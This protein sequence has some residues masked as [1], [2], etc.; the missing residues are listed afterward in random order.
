MHLSVSKLNSN[1][2][3]Q[4]FTNNGGRLAMIAVKLLALIKLNT[5]NGTNAMQREKG[6]KITMKMK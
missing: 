2:T 6:M 5:G 3:S 1:I 4:L